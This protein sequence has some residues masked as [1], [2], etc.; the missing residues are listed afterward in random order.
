MSEEM[1]LWERKL[2]AFAERG[3]PGPPRHTNSLGV[4]ELD[5]GA[6]LCEKER[7]EAPSRGN[8]LLL[9]LES[10]HLL[11]HAW[12]RDI[13]HRWGRERH[14]GRCMDSPENRKMGMIVQTGSA[15]HNKVTI[16]LSHVSHF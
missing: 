8:P 15:V 14:G 6:G 2:S 5:P 13:P 4:N 11:K 3:W 16:S 1:N 10:G 7:S 9:L 12:L